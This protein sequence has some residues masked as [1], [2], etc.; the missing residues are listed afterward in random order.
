[1][2][3]RDSVSSGSCGACAGVVELVEGLC[4]HDVESRWR[5]RSRRCPSR[6]L[7]VLWKMLRSGC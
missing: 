6:R 2:L 4:E 7:E 3:M 1:M 5:C